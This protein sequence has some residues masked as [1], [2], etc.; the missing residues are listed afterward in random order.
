MNAE[1]WVTWTSLQTV[2]GASMA[3]LLL[4][5]FLKDIPPIKSVPTRLLALFVGIVFIAVIHVPQTPAEGLLDLLNGLLVGS[6]AVGGW[7]VINVT[8][9]KA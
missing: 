6:T 2:A 4:V 7:H 5:E 9:K 8:N 1:T 3:V